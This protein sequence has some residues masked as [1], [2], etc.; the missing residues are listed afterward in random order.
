MGAIYIDLIPAIITRGLKTG[1]VGA[2][3][4]FSLTS[5]TQAESGLRPRANTK[6]NS[7]LNLRT[8]HDGVVCVCAQ[9]S[10]QHVAVGISG[11]KTLVHS[12]LLL[13]KLATIVY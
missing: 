9:V 7:W 1:L 12:F 2:L 8:G 11:L 10:A 6:S 3:Q 13:L 4:C 5:E